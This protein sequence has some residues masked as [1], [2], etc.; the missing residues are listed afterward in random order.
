MLLIFGWCTMLITLYFEIKWEWQLRWS[1]LLLLIR[2]GFHLQTFFIITDISSIIIMNCSSW[3]DVSSSCC[4]FHSLWGLWTATITPWSSQY[5]KSSMFYLMNSTM[6]KCTH[7]T[8][9]CVNT[10]WRF[11]FVNSH[12]QFLCQLACIKIFSITFSVPV[13]IPLFNFHVLI[14]EINLVQMMISPTCIARN[15]TAGMD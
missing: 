5:G 7:G 9:E 11:I 6:Y 12:Y 1:L 13:L 10:I 14:P 15:T 3:F 4:C 8:I 2:L